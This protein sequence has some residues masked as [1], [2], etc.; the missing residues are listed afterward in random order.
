MG[1]RCYI[2]FMHKMIRNSV[3]SERI[4]IHETLF[5]MKILI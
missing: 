3:L 2:E 4:Q 5:Y 1:V